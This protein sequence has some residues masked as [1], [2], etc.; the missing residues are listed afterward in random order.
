M[1]ARTTRNGDTSSR[2][3]NLSSDFWVV[4]LSFRVRVSSSLGP[5][6]ETF[7]DWLE[8]GIQIFAGFPVPLGE[9]DLQAGGV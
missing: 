8:I 4:G 2:T 5:E 7:N 6:I 3:Q 9:P 1:A